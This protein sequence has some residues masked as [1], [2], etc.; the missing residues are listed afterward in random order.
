M[1]GKEFE[2]DSVLYIPKGG[3]TSFLIGLK[4]G[5]FPGLHVR[6]E[7]PILKLGKENEIMTRVKG[8]PFFFTEDIIG[9]YVC[10]NNTSRGYHSVESRKHWSELD[11]E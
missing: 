1:L 5:V 7:Y 2:Q 3:A 8:R 6:K 9:E 11:V 4:E 10:A